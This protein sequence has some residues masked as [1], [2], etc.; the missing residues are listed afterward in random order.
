MQEQL[1]LDFWPDQTG[2]LCSKKCELT[3]DGDLEGFSREPMGH[4][5]EEVIID[6]SSS[7]FSNDDC[8]TMQS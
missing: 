8:T 5:D 2:E 7:S 6:S 1:N 4:F 3:C